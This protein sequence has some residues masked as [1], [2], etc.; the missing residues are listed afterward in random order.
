MRRGINLFIIVFLF[1]FLGGAEDWPK[2]ANEIAP[3]FKMGEVGQLEGA[4]G[5]KLSTFSTPRPKKFKGTVVVISGFSES[6]LHYMELMLDLFKEGFRSVSYDHRGQGF[7]GRLTK[8]SSACHL[9]DFRFYVDDMKRFM[10]SVKLQ[11][12]VFLVSHSTGGLI[13]TYFLHEEKHPFKSVV[14]SAPY[15]ELNSGIFPELFVFGLTS[16]LDILGFGESFAPSSGDF[17]LESAKFEKNHLTHSKERFVAWI[18]SEKTYPETFI[19]GPTNRWVRETVRAARNMPLVKIEVPVLLLQA[20][21]DHYVL[22]KRQEGFCNRQT[23]CT[24]VLYPEAYHEI[25]QEK[26][27]IREDAIKR[28]R[29]LLIDTKTSL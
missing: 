18:E 25:L 24:R 5:V 14:L 20:G 23:A 28:I 21:E 26:D 3:F 8:N 16:L 1:P 4:G 7:S 15:Y 27:S 19:A 12:P 17:T 29:E 10:A 6:Y 2:F 13:S 9:D 22:L 11:P